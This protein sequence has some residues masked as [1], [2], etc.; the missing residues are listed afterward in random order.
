MFVDAEK[1]CPQLTD[2]SLSRPT[3]TEIDALETLGNPGWNSAALF[4][5]RSI[6]C[7]RRCA[8]SSNAR[9]SQLMAAAE[10][11]TLPTDLQMS[12][13]ANV[14]PS[15]HGYSG[16]I[17]TSF[18]VRLDEFYLLFRG[19]LKDFCPADADAHSCCPGDLQGSGLRGSRYGA[20]S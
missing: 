2:H 17:N 18:P 3:T 7:G 9:L 6:P 1:T 11:N 20:E 10:N 15:V 19:D 4:P 12:E 13:G 8:L 16:V 5:V 14:V